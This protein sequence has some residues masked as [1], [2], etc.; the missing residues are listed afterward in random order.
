MPNMD[1][2]L[3]LFHKRSQY[4]KCR[5]TFCTITAPQFIINSGITVPNTPESP[6]RLER[7]L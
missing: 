3:F 6:I 5:H 1:N 2:S 7:V 4:K